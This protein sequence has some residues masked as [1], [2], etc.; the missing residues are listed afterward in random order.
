METASELNTTVKDQAIRVLDVVAIGPLM[1]VGGGV[2]MTRSKMAGGL[3]VVS[4]IGTMLFN[5]DNWMKV[6]RAQ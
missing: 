4:G 2:L 1:I 3:L 5:L 6:R